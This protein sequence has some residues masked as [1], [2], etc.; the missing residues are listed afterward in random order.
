MKEICWGVLNKPQIKVFYENLPKSRVR[1]KL[2]NYFLLAMQFLMYLET[3]LVGIS[4]S[5]FYVLINIICQIFFLTFVYF[6]ENP[7]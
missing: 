4:F 1:L 7:W 2:V 5:N 6:A 3:K